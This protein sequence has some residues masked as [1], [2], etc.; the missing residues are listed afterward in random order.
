MGKGRARRVAE[1]MKEE[2]AEL[3][4]A[5]KDPRIGFASVVKVDL[6][7]DL[8]TAKVYI[9]VL[10]ED[11]SKANTIKGLQSAGGYVRSE[12]ARRLQIRHTPSLQF[13]LD[14]SIE[15]GAR[16]AALLNQV[17]RQERER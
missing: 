1:Q 10:G 3:I 11:E 9:S 13:L 2:I 17:Q 12:L 16:I 6:S 15:H 4:R 8:S 14:D 7:N 5:L